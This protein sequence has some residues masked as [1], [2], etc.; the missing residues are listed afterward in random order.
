MTNGWRALKKVRQDYIWGTAPQ[1]Y[2]DMNVSG[3][4]EKSNYYVSV[5]HLSQD[6]TVR[7]YGGFKR[8]NAQ[9]NLDIQVTEKLKIGVGFNGRLESRVNPGV[10]GGDDYWLPRYA[11]LR[12]IPTVGPYANG[13]PNYPQVTSDDKQVN[14]AILSYDKS[15]KMKEDWR[16]MQINANAEYE[17]IKGLKAKALVSYYYANK[18]FNNHE[19]T[20]DLYRYDKQTDQYLVDYTMNTPYRERVHEEVTEMTSNIQLAYEKK[21]GQHSLDAVAGLETIK[22][23]NPH[24]EHQIPL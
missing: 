17:I 10:P 1:S 19:Y 11:V 23:K 13:N 8:T 20:Y 18:L 9:M 5:G 22:R 12:N 6:A 16:V 24:T 15:G 14:F 7:N 2:V 4:S 21:F 3:G